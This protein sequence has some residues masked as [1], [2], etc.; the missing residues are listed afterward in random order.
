MSEPSD[1]P[2]TGASVRETGIADV[3]TSTS[4][5]KHPTAFHNTQLPILQAALDVEH[6]SATLAPLLL[7]LAPNGEAPT[8][9][10]AKLL[11]FKQGNR[12]LIRYELAGLDRPE[13]ALA[14]GKIFPTLA[15]AERVQATM[16]SLWDEVFTDDPRV[17]IPRPL[18][19]V[20]SMAMLLYVPA[21]GQLLS[22]VID[23]ERA[24]EY[25]ELAGDWL[26]RL[27]ASQLPLDRTFHIATEVV[28]LQ[29]WSTLI[30]QRYPEHAA[31]ATRIADYLRG[32]AC[33]LPFVADVPIHK[34]FHYGHILVDDGLK[35]IDLDEMRLGDPN[36]DLA[37]FC[38]N[39]HL[40]AY[41]TSDMPFQFSALQRTF[42]DA[43]T[44]RTGWVPD[45]R[46]LYFYAY[47]CL[48]IVKQLC[49]RRGLRPRPEGEE[50]RRQVAVMLEQ[51]LGSLP[52]D[53]SKKLA[54]RFAT[55]IVRDPAAGEEGGA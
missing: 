42:L 15:Q 39:L 14:F 44:R 32:Q 9:R 22:E 41:R 35:V 18:G 30:G 55:M 29:A 17:S 25:V 53:G 40:L 27:H 16:Q 33:E 23:G 5:H 19:C 3:M 46:F 13:P 12:G 54:G 10:Y 11:A 4:I 8:V 26:G 36:F 45:E 21:E 38:A 52:A 37:H 20:P 50:Q 1:Q 24:L 7:P 48:K 51:G 31:A 43:Y 47:T 6:M 2:T 28:N 34:D 49:T